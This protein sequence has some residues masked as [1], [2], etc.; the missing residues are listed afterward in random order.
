MIKLTE[1]Q[2]AL[3]DELVRRNPPPFRVKPKPKLELR[4]KDLSPRIIEAI[5]K[6]PESVEVR[7]TA[8]DEQGVVVR[9]VVRG[10][11]SGDAR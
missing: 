9:G 6:S 5:R 10:F 1:E 11:C 3:A 2:Q 7:V 4:V 8:R